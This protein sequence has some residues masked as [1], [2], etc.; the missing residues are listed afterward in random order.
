MTP[1]LRGVLCGL[2]WMLSPAAGAQETE[3]SAEAQAPTEAATESSRATDEEAPPRP[4]VIRRPSRPVVTLDAGGSTWPVETLRL[5]TD[6]PTVDVGSMTT[7][8]RV[9]QEFLQRI[10]VRPAVTESHEDSEA[11][12]STREL[13]ALE[14]APSGAPARR[15]TPEPMLRLRRFR[16]LAE[17]APETPEQVVQGD[18]EGRD[19][20][21]PEARVVSR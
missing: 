21:E 19:A 18:P 13:S 17:L 1:F 3:P 20:Q 6:G 11:T 14:D 8:I 10:A 7:G 16:S 9:D 5:E 12:G 2:V 4:Q 15:D